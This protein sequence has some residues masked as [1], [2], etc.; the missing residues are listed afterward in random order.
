[1]TTEQRLERLERENR[2]MRRIGAV[3]VAVAAAVL[4][5]GQG[6]DKKLPDLEVRSLVARSL[7]ARSLVVVDDEGTRRVELDSL[8]DSIYLRLT[9]RTGRERFTLLAGNKGQSELY[10]NDRTGTTKL[11][12]GVSDGS[13]YLDMTGAGRVTLSGRDE[14][15]RA[16]LATNE[17]GTPSL[18][19]FDK[20][21]KHI[22]KAPKD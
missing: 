18:S 9:D 19:F 10:F 6:K 3:G 16:G 12:L 2:W 20:D 21:G 7:V 8:D 1:M 5:I 17:D 14:K 11:A 15:M 4:L 22:W 13:P